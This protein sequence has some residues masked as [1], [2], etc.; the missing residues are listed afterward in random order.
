MKKLKRALPALAWILATLVAALFTLS[1][2]PLDLGVVL[3][4]RG[5]AAERE[6]RRLGLETLLAAARPGDRVWV[7]TCG[8][9]LLPGLHTRKMTVHRE[10]RPQASLPAAVT[11]ASAA[12]GGAA[13]GRPVFLMIVGDE[14]A[15][16]L[17]AGGVR[18][19][20]PGS[21]LRLVGVRPGPVLVQFAGNASWK[22]DLQ[23]AAHA[24]LAAASAELARTLDRTRVPRPG[25]ATGLVGIA[26]MSAAFLLWLRGYRLRHRKLVVMVEALGKDYELY[27]LLDGGRVGIAG[28]QLQRTAGHV[29]V[30]GLEEG[31][32]Y[33]SLRRGTQLDLP[34][35]EGQ[36]LRI[37]V[38]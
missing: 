25:P 35:G 32:A 11:S 1:R 9:E 10:H 15:A 38:V 12:I 19:L 8:P 27:P 28:Y 31:T 13:G 2:S 29:E 30:R 22:F 5:T 17:E 16:P 18:G 33:P 3:E 26:S 14:A 6:Q 21:H 24:D 34:D 7:E 20:P 37:H 36:A 23:E 4:G